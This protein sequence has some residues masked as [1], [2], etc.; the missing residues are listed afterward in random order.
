MIEVRNLRKSFGA[1]K[2][3]EGVTFKV[4]SGESVVIIGRSGGGKSVL[5]KHLIGLLSPDSGSVLIDSENLC[6]LNERQLIRVRSKFGM[7]FQGAALFDSLSVAENIGFVLRKQKGLTDGEIRNKISEV[8]EMVELPGTENKKPSELSGGMR[9]RVGLARAIIYKPQIVL[10]D[11][12][13]T[14]LDPVVSDSI[15]KLI[16]R[17]RDQLKVTTVVVTHD[18]RSARLLGQRI[19]MLHEGKIYF[20]GTPEEIFN[21]TDPVMHRF[22]NGISIPKEHY[23]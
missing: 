22:V 18:M 21:S 3:L 15:D 19:L 9:K 2:I 16:L 17:V 13:T 11:E 4:E 7:L 5:L 8:L 12:P 23:F 6:T 1:H 14:G 20:S 10:Y